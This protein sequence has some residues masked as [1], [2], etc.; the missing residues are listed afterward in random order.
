L[1]NS[2]QVLLRVPKIFH[3]SFDFLK[4]PV[5][6]TDRSTFHGTDSVRKS[7]GYLRRCR[8]A[9]FSQRFVDDDT[10]IGQTRRGCTRHW[11]GGKLVKLASVKIKMEWGQRKRV[12]RSRYRIPRPNTKQRALGRRNNPRRR[13]GMTGRKYIKLWP[14]R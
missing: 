2:C 10:P 13:R 4:A 11:R 3:R 5:I 12:E 6:A 9:G 1:F 8:V 7:S 14:C